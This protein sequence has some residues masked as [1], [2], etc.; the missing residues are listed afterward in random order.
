ML[1][2]MALGGDTPLRL[3]EACRAI[4]EVAAEHAVVV[5]H[6][7]GPNKRLLA[8]RREPGESVLPASPG[9]SARLLERLLTKEMPGKEIVSLVTDVEVQL[10]RLGPHYIDSPGGRGFAAALGWMVVPDA[11]GFTR[12]VPTL[13][14]QKIIPLE[15]IKSQ[16]N[17][18]ALLICAFG[19]GAAIAESEIG[20]WKGVVQ[21]DEDLAAALLAEQIGADVL[22]LLGNVDVGRV[23]VAWPRGPVPPLGASTEDVLKR[24]SLGPGLLGPKAEAACRFVQSTGKR[25]AIGGL[26]NACEILLGD[27]GIQV[28]AKP[29]SNA[30]A[31][32]GPGSVTV[33]VV[34]DNEVAVRLCRRVLEKAGYRVVSATDGL[35]AVS[36]ALAHTPDMILLDD[37]MPGMSGLEAMRMIKQQRPGTPIAMTTAHAKSAYD[38][39][40]FLKAG[41]DD[42]MIKPFRLSDLIEMAV[43]L[44][45]HRAAVAP[46]AGRRRTIPEELRRIVGRVAD[47]ALWNS[48]FPI[49]TALGKP[50][51]DFGRAASSVADFLVALTE[52]SPLLDELTRAYEGQVA[53][54]PELSDAPGIARLVA[55]KT[56]SR[57]FALAQ[58]IAFESNEAGKEHRDWSWTGAE[59]MFRKYE[60]PAMDEANECDWDELL[61]GEYMP[62]F[63]IR[64]RALIELVQRLLVAPPKPNRQADEIRR[65][66]SAHEE[67]VYGAYR[68]C[69]VCG[70]IE[71][72]AAPIGI[73]APITTPGGTAARNVAK[74]EDQALELVDQA[75]QA[76]DP[77]TDSHS[78]RVEDLAGR[79]ALQ[80]KLGAREWDLFRKAGALHDIGKIGIPDQILQKPGRLSDEEWTIMRRHS[81]IGA[82][83]IEQN[84]ALR[85]IASL[86]RHHHERWDGSGYPTR[87][88]GDAIPLGARI[89]AVAE[90]FDWLTHPPS[91]LRRPMD[92]HEALRDIR[93]RSGSWYD[94]EVVTALREIH[95]AH[96]S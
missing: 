59:S 79:L 73:H 62:E 18:G 61:Q 52:V 80:L 32:I 23:E 51:F 84:P 86:V 92:V 74:L 17:A 30:D 3:D 78:S 83:L 11:T 57:L 88:K 7:N 4:A 94:P 14:P 53:H 27:R 5:T 9:A 46:T 64:S 66:G 16:I 50:Q 19:V 71:L 76:R 33:L 55:K 29:A 41:A 43:K 56:A 25:A 28:V 6:S 39:A 47:T 75:L 68:W 12:C 40:M 31:K 1:V 82:D 13:E 90:S 48:P 58:S 42:V 65:P 69:A 93:K 49:S 37:A 35:G 91:F 2:V 63:E 85:E 70:W 54:R 24:L 22:M 72:M 81:D 89:I 20:P 96:Q 21:I 60:R 87:M 8:K 67:H 15:T 44:T 36:M 38:R 10:V 45:G 34:D 26:A 95:R 77:Y